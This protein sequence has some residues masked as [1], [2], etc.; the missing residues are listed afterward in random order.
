[1]C[2]FH[3]SA[4]LTTFRSDFLLLLVRLNLGFILREIAATLL[5]T[6]LLGSPD[7]RA[8]HVIKHFFWRR[9]RG[10]EALRFRNLLTS[11]STR[12][13]FFWHR[14]RGGKVK[15]THI[16]RLLSY[17]LALLPVCECLKVFPLDS[18]VISFCFFFYFTS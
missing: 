2:R 4:P 8:I 1:M 11:P 5:H 7:E 9:C 17:F 12:Q 3:V 18:A 10:V 14:C 15:G 16:L 13:N 6:F